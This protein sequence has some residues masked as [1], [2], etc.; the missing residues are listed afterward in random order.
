[1]VALAVAAL[2][3]S[4][5]AA[6]ARP[7]VPDFN[8]L[9][10][11]GHN[12]QLRRA[13]GRV[14][15][16]FF[17]TTGCPVARK[18]ASKLRELRRE[19]GERGVTLWIINASAEDAPS[20]MREEV[21][22]LG[23]WEFT[24]LRDPNQ[25]VALSME[26][27]RTAEVVAINTA[28]WK[29]IY[30]GALDDQYSEGAERP[31]P[32]RSFLK[33]AL[34]DFLSGN[35][36]AEPR[37]DARGCR[38][39]YASTR[40]PDYSAQVAPIFRRHCT[41]C[42]R[43]GGIG[44]WAMDGHARVR[45]FSRMIEEVLLTRRMPP[46]DPDP[47]H[48]RFGNGQGLTREETQVLLRWVH[49]DAPGGEG[50]DPL[51]E[52]LPELAEW[53]TGAPD[54]VLRMPELEHVPATGVLDYRMIPLGTPFTNDVWISASE[55]KPGNRKVVHHVILYGKW[56]GCSDGG[57]GKGVF[58]SGWAPGMP[59]FR[60]PEGVAR[61]I[62]GGAELTLEL[63]YTTIGVEQSDL[64]VVGLHFAPG[65]QPR[66][67]EVRTAG[68][69]HINIPPGSDEARH[70]GTCAFRH[71]ATIYSFTPHMHRRGKWMRYEL[72]LP[73]GTQETLLHVPRY[74]FNW[75]W[76]YVLEQPRRVP[77]GA[78]LMVSG[79]FDNSAGNGSNPD[80]HKRIHFGEQS[81]DEMF[82]GFFEAAD[83]PDPQVAGDSRAP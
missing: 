60:Y 18:S 16:L 77:A 27:E 26:V 58:L 80:P 4:A 63:H 76:S 1:M 64:T 38:I 40:I 66:A 51:R 35:P 34:E 44:P 81:W 56:P 52:P 3:A 54:I 43:D 55:I 68:E 30:Q 79:A 69:C 7:Q 39:A 71:P 12:H 41:S 19:F 2:L 48:G 11:T 57:S 17:T 24:Y 45:K 61:K 49:A 53:A 70:F 82:I 65:P 50:P 31:A 22:E 29:V 21:G 47:E 10:L 13:E 15:V 42:H 14:V 75:Q 37:T 72:L 73:D 62:P 74:D 6:S 46:W 67:V 20:S 36:V 9:D 28:D 25:A 5:V 32:L 8:L 78:W 83:E 23:L 33:S 59:A